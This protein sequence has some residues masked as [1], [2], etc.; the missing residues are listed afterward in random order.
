M[1]KRQTYFNKSDMGL[2]VFFSNQKYKQQQ[3][4]IQK[5]N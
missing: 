1:D 4:K 3:Q 5:K 2:V